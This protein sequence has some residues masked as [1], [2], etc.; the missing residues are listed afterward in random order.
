MG[1]KKRQRFAEF[2]RFAN[3]YDF[4][5]TLKGNWSQTV[6]GNNNPI[7]LELGCGKGE[8]TVNLSEAYPAKNFIGVDLKSNR[9]W[10]GAKTALEKQL[11][12]VAFLRGIVEKIE[13]LFDAGEVDEIWITFPDPYPKDKHEKHRLTHPRFLERYKQ[14]L[15]P[16]GL[17]HFKTDDDALF[18]YTLDTLTQLGIKPQ[19]VCFNVHQEADVPEHLTSITTYYETL[20]MGRGC[21]IKYCRFCF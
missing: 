7:V 17:V 5:Y 9:M 11:K 16:G 2:E 14:I 13:L 18:H 19:Y 20:F 15:K 3:T 10:R 21:S 4:D 1:K 6:F 12:N 8:Y